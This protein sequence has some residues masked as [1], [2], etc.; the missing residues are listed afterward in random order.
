MRAKSRFR[1]FSSA[2]LVAWSA[3]IV[4]LLLLPGGDLPA[5]PGWV[6]ALLAAISDKLV[7]CGLFF[8]W[9]GLAAG[10][11]ER[12]YARR[13]LAAIFLTAV[14]LGGLLE[15]AQAWVP[16]RDPSWGDL[17]ADAFGALLALVVLA[18]LAAFR[19]RRDPCKQ[20]ISSRS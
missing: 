9:A 5:V 18:G 14:A 8:V 3:V 13:N 12:I 17:A 1:R 15:L 20:G 4:F 7:H 10:A 19:V 16:G 11:G 6:P 2:A